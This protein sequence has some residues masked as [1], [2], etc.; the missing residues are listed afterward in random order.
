MAGQPGFF[1]TDERLWWLSAA[2]DPLER[3]A[4]V[5]DFELFRPELEVA[6]GRGDRAKGGRPPY[7]AVL[8]FRILVLQAL[9]TLSDDQAEYQLRDR[10]S[11]MRFAGLA[12][13]DAVP[14][15][16]T[17]WLFREQ[18]VRAGAFERLFARFDAALSERGFL[19]M[20]GQIVDATV[21]EARRPRLTRAEKE[22]VKGGGVPEDWK[23][24]RARQI[25]R[26]GRWTLKRGKRKPPPGGAAR[27]AAEI[28]VPMFGY[29]NHVGID[30]EHGFVRRF[31]VTH[32]AAHDGAQLGAVLD[33]G[34]T[35][36]SV[37]ADTAYRSAANI[38]MLERRGLK[39]E[40]QRAKPRGRPMPRH[41]ARGNA[42]R[43][44]IRARVEHVFAAQK[45]RFTL[46][47]RTV[48]RARATAKLAMANLAYNFTRLAWLE[49]RA[50]T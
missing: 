5:V 10:L 48:G 29:K 4:A 43:A 35:A 18:L 47:I 44:R 25:D 2:G 45:R 13:H 14:D 36:G 34:N 12:L 9:Y 19:A 49:A 16:K 6:L 23:P 27:A 31:K 1:D 42:R 3:L 46:V 15:A 26:E 50:A 40:F 37:W 32:A 24:A 28:A 20:G 11:F 38:E 7:D 17:I 39:P 41:V 21:V 22:V 33:P 8:M 30:R